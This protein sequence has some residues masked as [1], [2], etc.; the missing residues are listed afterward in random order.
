VQINEIKTY[1]SESPDLQGQIRRSA[2]EKLLH[3]E[4]VQATRRAAAQ[5]LV[6]SG[7]ILKY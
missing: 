3:A 4:A 5:W 6:E 1:G 7:P 2:A